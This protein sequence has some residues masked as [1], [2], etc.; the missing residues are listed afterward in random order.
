MERPPP[1]ILAATVN[2]LKVQAVIKAITSG[3]FELRSTSNGSRIARVMADYSAIMHHLG[4]ENL[5]YYTCHPKS[6]KPAKAVIGI[7]SGTPRQRVYQTSLW[8]WASVS[9]ASDR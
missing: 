9:S 6:L 7:S 4:A 1:I 3:S 8:H 5:S 2:L